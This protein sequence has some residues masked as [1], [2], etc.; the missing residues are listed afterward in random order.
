MKKRR[1]HSKAIR[2]TIQRQWKNPVPRPTRYKTHT[3]CGAGLVSFSR[4]RGPLQCNSEDKSE[5]APILHRNLRPRKCV[6]VVI[7][8]LTTSEHNEPDVP[9][10]SGSSPNE[11]LKPWIL[12]LFEN[13]ANRINE[14]LNQ[15][16]K[17]LCSHFSVPQPNLHN[18][19]KTEDKKNSGSPK[20]VDPQKQRPARKVYKTNSAVPNPGRKMHSFPHRSA[21]GLEGTIG[22]TQPGF[23]R[24]TR[25]NNEYS[26]GLTSQLDQVKRCTVFIHEPR[27][28]N[29][30]P[31]ESR[32][33]NPTTTL[34]LYRDFLFARPQSYVSPAKRAADAGYERAFYTYAMTLKILC[35]DEEYFSRFTR[36]S[37]RRMG[38][39]VRNEDPVWVNRE[40]D[41]FITKRHLFTSTVVPL[42]YSCK[43]S[44]CLELDWA[45]WY[46]EHSKAT[47]M[48]HC[49]TGFPAFDTW[50]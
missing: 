46:I 20:S 29:V 16:E 47:D 17:T 39:V 28:P 15:F 11:D 32:T 38:M 1:I 2:Q 26:H 24:E 33:P 12:Q 43:C 50:Q 18:K 13:F 21:D 14:R 36:E 19:G 6:A 31:D 7:E 44:P 45:L 35:K 3:F 23:T 48:V 30:V 34:T 25:D 41:R 10:Q 40:S 49:T 37:V 9:P 5:G 4:D 22:H 8:D 27:I 42:F